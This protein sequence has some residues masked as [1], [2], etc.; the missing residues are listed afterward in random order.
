MLLVCKLGHERNRRFVHHGDESI[1]RGRGELDVTGVNF[2]SLRFE[3][4]PDAGTD[5]GIGYEPRFGPADSSCSYG[6]H[7]GL[8]FHLHCNIQTGFPVN[9]GCQSIVTFAYK[10]SCFSHL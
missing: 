6:A 5:Y 2:L 8:P 9:N 4:L 7:G 10:L 1:E 3:Q